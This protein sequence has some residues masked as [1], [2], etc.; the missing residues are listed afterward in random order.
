MA[1]AAAALFGARLRCIYDST[2]DR[3]AVPVIV[4]LDL[5]MVW[6]LTAKPVSAKTQSR[7]NSIC[8][9]LGVDQPAKYP[10]VFRL[11]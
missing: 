5:P 9:E 2:A 7:H 4:M 1:L 3:Q 8:E 6:T 10:S 11:R